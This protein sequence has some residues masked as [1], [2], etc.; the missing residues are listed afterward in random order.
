MNKD[1][2]ICSPISYFFGETTGCRKVI[3]ENIKIENF[4]IKNSNDD[5]MS[6]IE[7]SS[8][9]ILEI[10]EKIKTNIFNSLLY[11]I[12]KSNFVLSNI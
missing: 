4:E 3:Y 2:R 10:N 6:F 9:F 8:K 11:M 12:K 7:S 5:V 1:R